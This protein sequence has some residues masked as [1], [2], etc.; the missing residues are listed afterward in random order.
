MH[1]QSKNILLSLCVILFSSGIV[2][3]Q[4]NN[5]LTRAKNFDDNNTLNSISNPNEGEVVFVSSE[6][7][8]F[9]YDG[10]NWQPNG[11]GWKMGGNANTNPSVHFLGT[12][13][14]GDLQ[15]R[16]N[17][18]LGIIVKNNG[19][20]GV[21]IENP[22][23][24]LHINSDINDVQ[25]T[26]AIDDFAIMGSLVGIGTHNPSELLHVNGNIMVSSAFNTPDYVFEKYYTNNMSSQPEYE[27]ID[28]EKVKEFTKQ[29]LHLPNVP[30]RADLQKKGG[31]ILNKAIEMNLEKIEE[32]FLHSF[33][34][35]RKIKALKSEIELLKN[36]KQQRP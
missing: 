31:M 34:L 30:S 13:D 24:L 7:T 14:N 4:T 2:C 6:R 12:T 1:I 32:L 26:N 16:S 21:N 29:N 19:R 11:Y 17:N 18:D 33:E 25:G 20:I 10:T 28:L 9:H 35:S 36:E 27:F 3:S 22:L 8:I 5:Q 15:L 23:G